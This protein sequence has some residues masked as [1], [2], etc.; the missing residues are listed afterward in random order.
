MVKI[1]IVDANAYDCFK[2]SRNMRPDDKAELN[3]LHGDRDSVDVLVEQTH[4]SKE[5][6]K[7]IYF[8]NVLMGIGGCPSNDA[9][10]GVPWFLGTEEINN[11][12]L[13][14][15][16]FAIKSLSKWRK[17]HKLL[18]NFVWD[19]SSAKPWLV[20][21]GFNME[22]DIAFTTN[23]GGDFRKFYLEGGDE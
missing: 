9:G 7:A 1:S 20:K 22:P 12:K 19:G 6:C 13:S 16:K 3:Y 14:F 4:V 18:A 2:L 17:K 15:H 21:L 5:H 23:S 8:D 10:I 11:H